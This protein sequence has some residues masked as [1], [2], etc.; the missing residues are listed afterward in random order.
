MMFS[1]APTPPT[2]RGPPDLEI[3]FGDT[4]SNNAIWGEYLIL[5]TFSLPGTVKAGIR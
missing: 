3:A 5:A 4:K 1:Q 2:F